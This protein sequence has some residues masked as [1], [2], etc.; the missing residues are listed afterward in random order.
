M[1]RYEQAVALAPDHDELQ[2]WA[3]IA[4]FRQGREDDAIALFRKAFAQNPAM[5]R[6]VPRLVPLGLVRED[7]VARITDAA[8]Q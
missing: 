2:F 1:A 4:L 3:G 7:A 5:A 8:G 6:L